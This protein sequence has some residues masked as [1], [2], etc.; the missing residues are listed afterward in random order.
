[1][2][3]S[4]VRDVGS[5]LTNLATSDAVGG[6]LARLLAT[7]TR[8]LG[9]DVAVGWLGEARKN[10]REALRRR[11]EDIL[12]E[13]GVSR[14][15]MRRLQPFIVSLYPEE[16]DKLANAGAIE[17]I[18]DT[19]WAAVPGFRVYSDRWG[20]GWNGPIAAEPEDLIA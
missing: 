1:M 7:E 13:T 16:I 11:T 19:F 9:E 4:V 15:R 14:E 18:E 10:N 2:R 8:D 12:R 3:P 20:F 17:K 6:Y 5:T